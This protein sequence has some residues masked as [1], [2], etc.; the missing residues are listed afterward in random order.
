MDR[1]S[2]LALAKAGK[3]NL[4]LVPCPKELVPG[5][6]VSVINRLE[7]GSPSILAFWKGGEEIS[8]RE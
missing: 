2:Q 3:G 1:V 4:A 6:V 5:S 8:R 7:E